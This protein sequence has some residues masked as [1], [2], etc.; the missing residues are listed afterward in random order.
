MINDDLK[1]LQ[2]EI[3]KLQIKADALDE[4]GSLINRCI[5][6]KKDLIEIETIR[7]IIYEAFDRTRD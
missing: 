1:K 2:K 3:E 6:H 4:I 7:K 5:I